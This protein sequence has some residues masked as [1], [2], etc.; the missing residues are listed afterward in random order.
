[1]FHSLFAGWFHQV[2]DWGY[3]GVFL[4]M[5]IEST[6]FPL[7]SE[8]VV[9]PAA[10]WAEQGRF[11]FWGVVAA[12]TL[13]SWFG[14]ALSYLVARAIGR[15]LILRY[16]RYV[17]VPERKWLLAERWIRH[18]STAG[19]FFARL[20][21]V[22]RHLVSLPAGAA[23]MPFGRFSLMT[24]TGSFLWC[25]VLAWFG[26]RVLGSEP[27]LLDDPLAM[28][29][30]LREKLLWFVAAAGVLLALYVVMDVA[31]RRLKRREAGEAEIP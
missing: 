6:V 19:V 24:L 9:P 10:Y 15:P 1:M 21:P 5:A 30:V 26:A 22:V 8:L 27:T 25:F 17:F 7:P 31:G 2:H 3:G 13:G 20:L 12:A 29:H 14:S 16:G 28:A 18:Y 23:R 4:M 11:H